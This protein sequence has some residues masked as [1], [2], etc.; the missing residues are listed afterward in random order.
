MLRLA[1]TEALAWGWNEDGALCA[2]FVGAIKSVAACA[3]LHWSAGL[4]HIKKRP[5]NIQKQGI[6]ALPHFAKALAR[7]PKRFLPLFRY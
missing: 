5:K 2:V 1:R 7:P 3:G 6:L 4:F